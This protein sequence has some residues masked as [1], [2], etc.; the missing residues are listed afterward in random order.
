MHAHPHTSSNPPPPPF[1][2]ATQVEAQTA[3]REAAANFPQ[4]VGA[5]G[6]WLMSLGVAPLGDLFRPYKPPRDTLTKE[7]ARLLSTPSEVS[8]K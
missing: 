4:P 8:S 7:V 3:F 2:S 1:L 5:L 6:G